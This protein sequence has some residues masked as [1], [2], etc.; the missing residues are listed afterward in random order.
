MVGQSQP[1][2][3]ERPALLPFV[4]PLRE[5]HA[6]DEAALRG[7]EEQRRVH[8]LTIHQQFV[9]LYSVVSPNKELKRR[10]LREAMGNC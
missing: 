1:G 8:S 6:V 5:V 9:T 10:R 7:R 2:R 4:R 3:M